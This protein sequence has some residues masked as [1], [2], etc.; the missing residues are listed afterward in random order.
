MEKLKTT[1]KI[2]QL[3]ERREKVVKSIFVSSYIPQKC[4]IATFSKDLAKSL[5]D[6]N[7]EGL[8]EI[9]GIDNRT[10]NSFY[11]WEVKFRVSRNNL[12]DYFRASEYVNQSSAD[13]VCIQHEF[14]LFGGID[15]DYLFSFLRNLNKP[16]I[17]TLHTV[18]AKPTESQKNNLIRLAGLSNFL[19]VMIL[20]AKNQLKKIYGVDPEKVVVI[21]HGVLD[22]PFSVKES[23]KRFHWENKKVLLISGLINKDK[24]IEYVIKAMPKILKEF[25]KSIL[26]IIG[27]T[28][29]AILEQEG[30]KYRNGL[31]Q[32][33]KK[34]GVLGNIRFVNDY[35]SLERLLHYYEASDICL[36]PHLKR[37]QASSG[38]LAYALGMGKVC[39]STPYLYAKEMLGEGRGVLVPF[40]SSKHIEKLVL[41]IM[42][43]PKLESEL[44]RNAY[45]IGR[46][47]SWPRVGQRYL[48]LFRYVIEDEKNI[49]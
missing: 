9:I 17:T 15:G 25:P 23:K 13:I 43:N 26:A 29:P 22:K 48:N 33:A 18:P 32:I 40:R 28:H 20:A 21:H 7:P 35:L 5:N 44:A 49:I 11:P 27:Q 38:T 41:E 36:T 19:V 31:K 4:G 1:F 3:L 2:N 30:E 8:T 14:G 6:L 10:E 16:V 47:M 12:D 24:G 34:L 37:E 45:S 46:R 39:I 42:R